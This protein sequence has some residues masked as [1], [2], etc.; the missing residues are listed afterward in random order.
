MDHHFYIGERVRF[1]ETKGEGII[2]SIRK[3]EVVVEDESGFDWPTPISKIVKI[4][5]NK[6]PIKEFIPEKNYSK[7]ELENALY[8]FV[9]EK[10]E[11]N[12]FQ[13]IKILNNCGYDFLLAIFYSEKNNHKRLFFDSIKAKTNSNFFEISDLN[14]LK[15]IKIQALPVPEKSSE[16]FGMFEETIRINSSILLG[17]ETP[18]YQNS[19]PIAGYFRILLNEKTIN[20]SLLEKNL[21]KINGD[22]LGKNQTPTTFQSQSKDELVV[23]LHIEELIE[24]SHKM[25]AGDKLNHQLITFEKYFSTAF[26][27]GFKKLIIIH[28]VGKGVLKDNIIQKLKDYHFV[29]HKDADYLRFG[30]GATEI[31]LR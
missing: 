23:D 25:S 21:Q 10:E 5:S 19:L 15:S 27:Q 17:D 29:K 13:K 4:F 3:N 18:H 1:L 20:D 24:N 7:I 11:K 14:E 8:L 30:Y 22:T 2:K 26:S 31:I 28:G 16:A 9:P 12:R 6:E